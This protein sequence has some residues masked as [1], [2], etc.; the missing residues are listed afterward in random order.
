MSNDLIPRLNGFELLMASYAMAHLKMDMLL[1]ETGYKPTNDQ[2]L[3]IFLTNSME[4]AH[5]DTGT[6]FS[7]WL[8]DEA[9]QANAIKRDTPV[10]VIMGNPPYS[11]ESANKGAW[12]ME[13]M[14]DYKKEP[15]GIQKL[16]ERNP[17]WI[18]DD[19]VKFMRFGQYFIEKNGEG[20]LAFINPHGYC[21][22]YTSPSPRD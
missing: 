2:R 14:E 10:M 7:S 22:L 21:L 5:P 8:S 3:R 1:T 20:I 6:L 16:Q 17:K 4:E 15:G 11:G 12:I 13:L 19:Y 9:D 18:N